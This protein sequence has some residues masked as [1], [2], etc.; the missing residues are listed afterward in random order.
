MKVVQSLQYL[1]VL[2]SYTLITQASKIKS[3]DC[4]NERKWYIFQDGRNAFC[5]DE[6]EPCGP[7]HWGGFC[8]SGNQR[9]QSPIDLSHVNTAGDIKNRFYNF[10]MSSGYE[11]TFETF[12]IQNDGHSILLR[13]PQSATDKLQIS[14]DLQGQKNYQFFQL[15]FHWGLNDEQGS[16]H[17]LKGSNYAMELHMV[18]WSLKYKSIKEALGAPDPEAISVVGIFV[19][20]C[21]A[22][23]RTNSTAFTQIQRYVEE[24]GRVP[25]VEMQVTAPFSLGPFLPRS[26][27]HFSYIGSLTT[28]SCLEVVKWTMLQKSICIQKEELKTFH[29]VLTQE[30]LPLGRNHRPTQSLGKRQVTFHKL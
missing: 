23:S 7:S 19:V 5:Y 6:T 9:R 11:E 28:P 30:G 22:N 21:P 3:I 18:H 13:L 10:T 14:Y 27:S 2:F 17:T 8:N 20:V 1:G 25:S 29:N 26:L 16:E 12:A 15:H 4:E 24:V